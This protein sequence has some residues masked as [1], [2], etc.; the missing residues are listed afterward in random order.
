MKMNHDLIPMYQDLGVCNFPVGDKSSGF[1]S[2]GLFGDWNL[3]VER[4]KELSDVI[5]DTGRNLRTEHWR[6]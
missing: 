5:S 2:G 1:L 3:E 4:R 6:C